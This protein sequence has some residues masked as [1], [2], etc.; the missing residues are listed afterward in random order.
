MIRQLIGLGIMAA[1]L[2]GAQVDLSSAMK[3]FLEAN[4]DL[5]IARNEPLKAKADIITAH[6]HPNPLWNTTYEFMNIEKRFNDQARGS[7]AQLTSS[8]IH[9]IETIS[10]RDKRVNLATL[11]AEYQELIYQDALRLRTADLLDAYFDL[12]EDQYDLDNAKANRK[13]FDQ[14]LEVAKAK[15]DHGFLSAMD[16]Q[17]LLL[18][19]IDYDKE[20]HSALLSLQQDRQ[21]LAMM[22][23]VSAEDLTV[24]PV[25]ASIMTLPS[26]DTMLEGASKRVDCEAA[27]K[28]SMVAQADWVM[29]KALA[30]PN[31]NVMAE[32]ASFGPLYEPLLGVGV[33]MPLP[34]FDR[35]AGDIEKARITTLQAREI[36]DKTLRHAQAEITTS[37]QTYYAHLNLY[38]TL[39]AGYESAKDLK[40]K[41]EKLF[42]IKGISILELLDGQKNFRDYQKAFIHGETQIHKAALL[43]KLQAGLPVSEGL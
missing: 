42:A 11:T 22:L 28:S 12:L 24:S 21:K 4:D 38:K 30:T 15:M 14:L 5:L 35:N 13:S 39:Q 7:N 20:V 18:Q 29:Q 6:E 32:Y 19:K 41:Q 37:Y 3:R 36:Y 17:K 26:L 34:I 31:V 16:Y 40:E 8:L 27:K 43:V 23:V 33:S 25:M 10:K 1:V 2:Q 9:T